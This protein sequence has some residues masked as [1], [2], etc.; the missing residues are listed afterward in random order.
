MRSYHPLASGGLPLTSSRSTSRDMLPPVHL[1][2]DSGKLLSDGSPLGSHIE[3][4]RSRSAYA[5]GAPE[6]I[7]S[8]I[9]ALRCRKSKAKRWNSKRIGL[10]C[11]RS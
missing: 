3:S 2:G 6:M 5:S 11:V 10:P 7:A 9:V 1:R 8:C 4:K